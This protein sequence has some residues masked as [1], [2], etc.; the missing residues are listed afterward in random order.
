METAIYVIGW[1]N[2][3]LL[4]VLSVLALL[5]ARRTHTATGR[6]L[7]WAVVTFT[8]ATL[9]GWTPWAVGET[10]L[11][12]WFAK[13][14]LELQ[15]L[16]PFLLL[17]LAHAFRPFSDLA[18]RIATIAFALIAVFVAVIP[19]NVTSVDLDLASASVASLFLAY[20]GWVV[21]ALLAV[22]RRF[23]VA[24]R[25]QPGSIRRRMSLL[26]A[27]AVAM[28]FAYLTAF[29]A[30]AVAPF[31]LMVTS[32]LLVAAST[33]AFVLGVAPSALL[34]MRWRRDE[35][36]E[37][38]EAIVALI[39]AETTE[40]VLDGI[41]PK[42]RR[43]VGA[44]AVALLHQDGRPQ[45]VEA[46]TPIAERLLVDALCSVGSGDDPGHQLSIVPFG[47]GRLAI[48]TTP[49]TPLV[50]D[51]ELE[52]LAWV[53]TVVE[54]AFARCAHLA[55]DRAVTER[56]RE[57]DRLKSEFVQIVAHDL[58][59]PMTAVAGLAGTL[60]ARWEDI[61]ADMKL[62]MLGNIGSSTQ[63]MS[64]L[65]VDVLDIAHIE[66]GE[67]RYDIAPFDLVR[68]VRDAVEDL[69]LDAVKG[70]IELHV[71]ED[72]TL[73]LA[74]G[75]K[76]RHRQVVANLLTNALKYSPRDEPIDV[77]VT[78]AAHELVVGIRDRG[79]GIAESEHGRIFEKF[80]RAVVPSDATPGSGLG[81]YICKAM[82]EAQ[83][84]RIWVESMPGAGATF[85]FTAPVA[86]H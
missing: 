23:Q 62:T 38:R 67:L 41:L 74:L 42:V 19:V 78:W 53:G 85:R 43:I 1:A 29:A 65:V 21:V 14:R 51:A 49:V 13:V 7:A 11:H 54:L 58:R 47:S 15:I 71:K 68:V 17:R 64:D 9:A 46:S 4:I 34:R 48:R 22:A 75:D 40:E 39:S 72:A 56:L 84:G 86:S 73:P 35:E 70:R 24:G 50:G 66:S 27:A 33:L 25:G 52:L 55:E 36:H 81:L 63:R 76:R 20:V 28:L 80:G 82:V 5:L 57:V 10:D 45:R 32:M 59:S 77:H 61:D 18:M 79:D 31:A 60:Q 26:S 30:W 16:F 37:L 44:S 6:L 83:G 12:A 2:N 8:V 3:V 69:Q